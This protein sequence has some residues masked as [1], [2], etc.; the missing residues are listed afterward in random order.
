MV[1]FYK[2]IEEEREFLESQAW[3]LL[4]IGYPA[5]YA[6]AVIE[7]IKHML[8][9][10]SVEAVMRILDDK[11]CLDEEHFYALEEGFEWKKFYQAHAFEPDFDVEY[12]FSRYA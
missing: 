1:T 7:M 5:P 4:K 2:E 10:E 6:D 8:K 12:K 11:Y 3:G 9:I